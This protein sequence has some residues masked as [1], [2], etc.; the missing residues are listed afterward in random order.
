[1]GRLFIPSHKE[2]KSVSDPPNYKLRKGAC[3][4][5]GDTAVYLYGGWD[6]DLHYSELYSLGHWKSEVEE[7]VQ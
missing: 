4:S 3:A 5:T 2:R 7:G 1:M 6:E